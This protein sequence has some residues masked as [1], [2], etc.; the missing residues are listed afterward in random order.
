MEAC[1]TG[2]VAQASVGILDVISGKRYSKSISIEPNKF[3]LLRG[4]AKEIWELGDRKR[5]S[6]PSSQSTFDHPSVADFWP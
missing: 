3:V 1:K 6:G 2:P 5:E 4:E